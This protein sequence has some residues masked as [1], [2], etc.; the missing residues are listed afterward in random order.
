MN[1]SG[2]PGPETRPRRRFEV[3]TRIVRA[4][5]LATSIGVTTLA[6]CTAT[7]PAVASADSGWLED[8][9]PDADA[10]PV[11]A[12]PADSG[13]TPVLASAWLARKYTVLY[14]DIGPA[15]SNALTAQAGDGRLNLLVYARDITATEAEVWIGEGRLLGNGRYQFVDPPMVAATGMRQTGPPGESLLFGYWV[16][17]DVE[18]ALPLQPG[19]GDPDSSYAGAPSTQSAVRF[20][21]IRDV[22]SPHLVVYDALVTRELACPV[23]ADGMNLL[24]V[25]DGDPF[26]SADLERCAPHCPFGDCPDPWDYRLEIDEFQA[27]EIELPHPL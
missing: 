25:L 27:V 7:E 9:G 15:I 14:D 26:G 4:L 5:V 12:D 10:T 19:S 3:D 2:T 21:F 24:D 11:P 18:F 16:R 22:D 13:P 20:D 8:G 6:G 1:S 23:W 17:L